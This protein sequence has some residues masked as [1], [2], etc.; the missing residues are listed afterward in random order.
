V[1]DAFEGLDRVGWP[2]LRH[3]YGPAGDVP[4][5]L[6]GLRSSDQATRDWAAFELMGNVY[7]QGGRWPASQHVVPFLVA[8]VDDPAT[9]DRAGVA[10]LLRAIALGDRSDHDLPFSPTATF[11]AAGAV[12]PAQEARCLAA[13][14]GTDDEWDSA[15]AIADAEACAHKWD[16][17]AYLAAGRHLGRYA[18]WVADPDPDLAARAA[19]LLAW[20]PTTPAT[21]VALIAMPPDPT[22][23]QPRASA[24][25][26]LAHLPAEVPGRT[27][28]EQGPGGQAKGWPG[29]TDRTAAEQGPG[30]QANGWPGVTEGL[31]AQLHAV[32]SPVRLTAAI[33]LA[34]QLGDRLP[35]AA[36]DVLATAGRDDAPEE[37]VVVPW[38]RSLTSFA[39]LARKRLGLT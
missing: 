9:P 14:D 16:R 32:P 23:W 29:G 2:D 15:R 7:H 35:A 34:Y 13:R 4:G 27:A 26:T 10:Q 12:T 1:I 8:L 5:Q 24:N 17:D 18:R 36:V 28:A 30:R 22:R 20:F 19:E 37:E 31:R 21:I 25:L 38:H 39:E 11:T 3:A 33:A 6:R